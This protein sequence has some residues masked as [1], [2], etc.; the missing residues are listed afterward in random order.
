MSSYLQATARQRIHALI[1]HFREILPPSAQWTSPY[2]PQLNAPVSPDDG[3]V[4]GYGELDG[5]R[6]FAAAQDGTFMGGAV[7]EVHGA[8]LVGILQK[9][10]Q[11]RAAAFIFLAES[12]G[13]R[14][15]E[16]NAGLIAVSEVMRALL[17]VRAAGIPV[18]VLNGGSNGCFGGIGV[19]ARCA[20][21]VIMS[22]AAR[23]AMSGPEVIQSAHGAAEFNAKDRALVW[24]TTGGKHR[25]LLGDCDLL[26]ADDI[27]AFRAAAIAAMRQ[28]AQQTA[29]L[30][31]AELE[32]EQQMLSQRWQHFSDC[33]EST[34][35]WAALGHAAPENAALPEV[36]Q[37][38]DRQAGVA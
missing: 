38:G 19:V 34:Q 29:A 12:G 24:R 32:R 26:V 16:A 37:V 13:V 23:L 27:A 20:N 33:K 11:E 18:I 21:V 14:L 8:K 35:I 15:H 30:S 5:R 17:A 10:V 36:A 22:E 28:Y 2:L 3:I 25:Y 1:E 4:I 7:G 9:A 31:L 6:V